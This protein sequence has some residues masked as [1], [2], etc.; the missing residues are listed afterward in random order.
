[1]LTW[2]EGNIENTHS[3]LNPSSPCELR[4]FAT[5]LLL[6]FFPNNPTICYFFRITKLGESIDLRTQEHTYEEVKEQLLVLKG[7]LP[8]TTPSKFKNI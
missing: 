3:N 6:P 8:T 2:S 7:L 4:S 5:P 1:M